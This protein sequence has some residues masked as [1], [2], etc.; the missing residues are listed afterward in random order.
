MFFN[1]PGLLP[2]GDKFVSN[3]ADVIEQLSTIETEVKNGE[4]NFVE[5][6]SCSNE[7]GDGLVAVKDEPSSVEKIEQNEFSAGSEINEDVV[8]SIEDENKLESVEEDPAKTNEACDK[9]SDKEEKDV[10]NFFET[11]STQ[12][13][14]DVK[15]DDKK[16]EN[17]NFSENNSNNKESKSISENIPANITDGEVKSDKSSS[18][19]SLS[20]HT[21]VNQLDESHVDKKLEEQMNQFADNQNEKDEVPENEKIAVNSERSEDRVEEMLSSVKSENNLVK[22]AN[23]L[24]S[25]DSLDEEKHDFVNEDNPSLQGVKEET[26]PQNDKKDKFTISFEESSEKLKSSSSSSIEEVFEERNA[27]INKD[28]VEKLQLSSQNTEPSSKLKFVLVLKIHKLVLHHTSLVKL[29]IPS[30]CLII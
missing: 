8:A 5:N 30:F 18:T 3:Q 12:G 19:S 4:E 1:V 6:V 20:F 27:N 16:E 15:S 26:L 10:E 24:K 28:E 11:S 25:I 17:E 14:N 29:V 22:S 7:I 2:S 13:S 21:S 23:S 9:S